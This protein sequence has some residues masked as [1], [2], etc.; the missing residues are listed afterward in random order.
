LR[1]F[2]AVIAITAVLSTV[3]S[4]YSATLSSASPQRYIMSMAAWILGGFVAVAVLRWRSNRP[5]GARHFAE[6][7]P[8]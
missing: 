6:S 4:Y 2:L 8:P 7:A 5:P 1:L 3:Q